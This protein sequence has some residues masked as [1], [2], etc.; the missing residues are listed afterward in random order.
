[1]VLSAASNPCESSIA[2]PTL[3][4]ARTS[5]LR[6]ETFRRG[7][8]MAIPYL[9]PCRSRFWAITTAIASVGKVA[10]PGVPT[11]IEAVA[12]PPHPPQ[13]APRGGEGGPCHFPP[14]GGRQQH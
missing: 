9:H 6:R 5:R 12:A 14:P 4:S 11:S 13:A 7:P 10:D 2:A 1:M 3:R 8:R